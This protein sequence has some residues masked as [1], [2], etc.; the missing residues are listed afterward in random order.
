MK[1]KETARTRHQDIA[2]LMQTVTHSPMGSSESSALLDLH[3]WDVE[4][5]QKR[6]TQREKKEKKKPD[7]ELNLSCC[8]C[9]C[10]TVLPLFFFFFFTTFIHEMEECDKN[11]TA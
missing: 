6:R 10:A 2:E 8:E 3:V 5:K 1:S 9:H 7:R 4:G 11:K